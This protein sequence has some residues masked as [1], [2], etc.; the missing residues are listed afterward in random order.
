MNVKF[1]NILSIRMKMS[2]I[3]FLNITRMLIGTEYIKIGSEYHCN[4]NTEVINF[5]LFFLH[6]KTAL[7]IV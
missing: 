7:S 6:L 3:F 2:M 5:I 1:K 4:Y